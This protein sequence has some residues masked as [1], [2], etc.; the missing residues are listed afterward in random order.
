MY[1]FLNNGLTN[2]QSIL[3]IAVFFNKFLKLFIKKLKIGIVLVK[4]I[5]IEMKE[6]ICCAYF[7]EKVL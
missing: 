3:K 4:E 7:F 2:S 5:R 1:P 6:R